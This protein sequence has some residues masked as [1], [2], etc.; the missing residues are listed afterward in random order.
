[1]KEIGGYLELETYEGSLFHDQALA[2]N[3]GR[4]CLEY[5]IQAKGIKKIHLPRFC[6]HSVWD[7]CEKYGVEM[8]FYNIDQ[9]F[10]PVFDK[11][12]EED[13]W[14]YL[15]NFYGQVSRDKIAEY[16]KKYPKLIVDNTM[17]YF[18]LPVKGVDTLYSCR[19]FVGTSDG[20]FLYTDQTD[21][22]ENLKRDQ[23]FDHMGFVLGRFERAASEFYRESSDNHERFTSESLMKMSRLTENLLRPVNYS[24]IDANRRNN[25]AYLH[26][27]LGSK[28]KLSLVVPEGPYMYPFYTPYASSLRSALQKEKIYLSL[29]WSDVFEMCSEDSL[30]YDYAQN[31]LPIPVDQRYTTEDMND[32][33]ERIEFYLDQFSEEKQPE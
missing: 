15:V 14:L 28:N 24:R 32:I 5:L 7:E 10:L 30:E 1:M 11:D 13:E 20:G 4:K 9:D 23:S 27:R 2:L 21:L 22:Y 18:Q 25:F 33:V 19:K 29:F 3:S 26:D 31:I 6:C 16:K 12:L 8:I 17:A